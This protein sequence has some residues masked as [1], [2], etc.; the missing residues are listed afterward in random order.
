MLFRQIS[1]L[2]WLCWCSVFF[3]AI[4]QQGCGV[5]EPQMSKKTLF[6]NYSAGNIESI[7]PAFAKNLYNMWTVHMVFNTLVNTNE[8]LKIEPCLAKS[9][10]VSSD[11]LTH[12][13]H[14]RTDVYFQDNPLFPKGKGRKMTADDVVYSFNRIIDPKVASTGAWIFNDKIAVKNPFVAINDSLLQI[15]LKKPFKPLPELLSMPYCSV[16]PK[17]V[18]EYWGKDFSAHVCGTGPFQLHFWDE[19]NVLVLNKNN[20]YWQYDEKG[21]RLPYLASIQIGFVDSKATEFFQFIQGKIDFVN[22]LDGSFKDLVL[23]KNGQLKQE[24]QG[25][26]NL[27]KSVYLN[28]EY[29]G[30]LMDSDSNLNAKN[31]PLQNKLVRQ[32]INYAIDKEKIVR[33]FKNGIGIPA[34]KGFIPKGML[35]FDDSLQYGYHYNPKKSLELLSEAGFP[36]GKGLEGFT[37]LVP[38][39]WADIVNF[40]ATEL[41]E[42]GIPMK[43]EIMQANMLRQLMSKGEAPAFRAQWIAD[44]PDA[45]TFLAFFNSRFPAPPNYTRYRNPYFDALYDKSLLQP[46]SIRWRTYRQ[47]DSLVVSDAPIVPLFYD[48][49]MHFTR[50]NITG[51]RSNPMNLI[52]VSRVRKM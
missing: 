47:M 31:Y 40:I 27:E 50:K 48:Q 49:M 32:A 2:R 37:I 14:L 25:K 29:I 4:H 51:F 45:E 23:T 43:V 17:E 35:T 5:D 46:D 42:V 3:W 18:V 20:N 12:Y 15:N 39:N 44:Y 21:N 30:F 8:H 33:Y 34:N 1:S 10:E 13:F 6:L 28:T 9:W 7:D 16:V 36:N 22:G 38:D 52:D 11:G 19:G 41:H 24:W 26:M